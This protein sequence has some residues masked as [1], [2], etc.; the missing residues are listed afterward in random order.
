MKVDV[1]PTD[2]DAFEAAAGLVAERLRAAAGTAGRVTVA[3][4]GGRSGR[5]VMV[6]LA[7]R[8]DVPWERVEWFWSDER[9]VPADDAHS[10][11]RVARDSLFVPRGVANQRIHPPPVALG[12]PARIAAEYAAAVPAAFDVVLLGVGS[13]AHVASLMPGARALHATEPVAAVDAAEV[14][15]EPHVARITITPPVVRAARFVVVTVTG[16]V[17]ARA[18]AAALRD[19]V[20]TER[21]PAQ[22][23]RPGERVAWVVDRPAAGELLRDAQPPETP[24]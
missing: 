11:V 12:D 1:Y 18:V 3:L 23:V 14:G 2:A 9:C 15:T 21:Y 19:P 4:S 6:A 7:A 22:L 24:Q 8:G 10:N 16:D 5:G 17:K 13:D 20:D